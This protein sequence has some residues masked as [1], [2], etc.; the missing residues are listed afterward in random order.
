MLYIYNIIVIIIIIRLILLILSQCNFVVKLQDFANSQGGARML[1]VTLLN[2]A[3]NAT[4]V[5]NWFAVC[6]GI[7]TVFVGL[8]CI[9][10]ICKILSFACSNKDDKEEEKTTS[11]P[12]VTNTVIENRQ[13]IIAAVTAACAEEMGTDVNAIRVLSFKKI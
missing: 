5:P 10:L 11:K 8:I 13:E 1:E 2:A 6:M 9:V 3:K 4:D 12:V 7:G